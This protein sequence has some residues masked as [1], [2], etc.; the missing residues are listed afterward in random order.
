MPLLYKDPA[1]PDT[2]SLRSDTDPELIQP[3]ATM[4]MKCVL[5]AVCALAVL[6]TYCH[7]ACVSAPECGASTTCAEALTFKTCVLTE[8]NKCATDGTEDAARL[9]LYGVYEPA[10]VTYSAVC[11][12]EAIAFSVVT[13]VIAVIASFMFSK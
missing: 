2:R 1:V 13:G 9:T 11:G 8:Y 4:T 6:V 12:A 7:A 10:S 3:P 5:L